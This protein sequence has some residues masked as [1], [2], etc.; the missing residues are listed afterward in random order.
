MCGWIP[1]TSN[2]YSTL[3]SYRP[4]LPVAM[5]FLAAA[6]DRVMASCCSFLSSAVHL[7]RQ[8]L[9]LTLYPSRNSQPHPDLRRLLT[10]YGQNVPRS[11]NKCTFSTTKMC[12]LSF[13]FYYIELK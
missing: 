6:V 10:S 8:T 7:L 5:D 13:N 1:P 11:L 3:M 9:R 12:S 2:S 4:L